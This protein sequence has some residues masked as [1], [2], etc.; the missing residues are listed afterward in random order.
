M[1]TYANV[2][3]AANAFF[4]GLLTKQVLDVSTRGPAIFLSLDVLCFC[5]ATSTSITDHRRA[6]VGALV[7]QLTKAIAL[8]ASDHRKRVA[9]HHFQPKGMAF[10]ITVS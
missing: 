4:L 7:A 5:C 2:V 6:I 1:D 9:A 8:V 10:P 3:G